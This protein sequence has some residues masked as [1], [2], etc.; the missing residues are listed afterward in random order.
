MGRFSTA[1]FRVNSLTDPN[2]A[3]IKNGEHFTLITGQIYY[4]HHQTGVISPLLSQ[5]AN[6]SWN[7]ISNKPTT[8]TGFG[9]SLSAADIP[10]LPKS[11]ISFGTGNSLSTFGITLSSSDI[12]T[13]LT[14]NNLTIN[15]TLTASGTSVFS[16]TVNF[17]S[18]TETVSF[19]NNNVVLNP[20][21]QTISYKPFI[22]AGT[23]VFANLDPAEIISKQELIDYVQQAGLSG[24]TLVNGSARLATTINITL[25]G[26]QVIDDNLTVEDD[27]ILVKNQTNKINNGL[28]LAKSGAW[29]RSPLMDSSFEVKLNTTVFVSGGTVNQNSSWSIT[30]PSNPTI[31]VD[32]INFTQFSGSQII[33]V[34]TGLSKVGNTISTTGLLA[35]FAQYVPSGTLENK[36]IFFNTSGLPEATLI[37]EQG[38]ELLE[39]ANKKDFRDYFKLADTDYTILKY[40]TQTNFKLSKTVGSKNYL[41]LWDTTLDNILFTQE[42]HT[43]TPTGTDRGGIRVTDISD[44]DSI[45]NADPGTQIN[46]KNAMNSKSLD[47]Y[48][49]FVFYNQLTNIPFIGDDLGVIGNVLTIKPGDEVTLTVVNI[50][51]VKKLNVSRKSGSTNITRIP[52][53]KNSLFI[54]ENEPFE[55]VSLV[56]HI[57]RTSNTANNSTYGGLWHQYLNESIYQP[58]SP[59]SVYNGTGLYGRTN[60]GEVYSGI[61]KTF[62]GSGEPTNNPAGVYSEKDLYNSFTSFRNSANANICTSIFHLSGSDNQ[63]D[64]KN[65]NTRVLVLV[66]N[67]K[68]NIVRNGVTEIVTI[69][70]GTKCFINPYCVNYIYI[71][72]NRITNIYRLKATP[73]APKYKNDV[74]GNLLLKVNT[75]LTTGFLH[76]MYP[77]VET[78]PTIRLQN[79]DT[80]AGSSVDL[81][82]FDYVFSFRDTTQE[83]I[84]KYFI[85]QPSTLNSF[86]YA[87]PDLHSNILTGYEFGKLEG[88][89]RV[90]YA[91]IRPP[92]TSAFFTENHSQIVDGVFN[93]AMETKLS[94]TVKYKFVKKI[95]DQT[96]GTGW[97]SD[98]N[99]ASIPQNDP[100]KW[101]Y[102]S[103]FLQLQPFQQNKL[104]GGISILVSESNNCSIGAGYRMDQPGK[105]YPMFDYIWIT[106]PNHQNLGFIV[107]GSNDPNLLTNNTGVSPILNEATNSFTLFYPFH[108]FVM[109]KVGQTPE[110]YINGM[111]LALTVMNTDAPNWTPNGISTLNSNF[112]PLWTTAMVP[113]TNFGTM[114]EGYVTIHEIAFG[115]STDKPVN[116]T[117]PNAFITNKETSSADYD[118]RPETYS[119]D[120]SGTKIVAWNNQK[121]FVV[122]LHREAKHM[123]YNLKDNTWWHQAP[124]GHH[125][126]K[127]VD[128]V[129]IGKTLQNPYTQ[130]QVF[131]FYN[132][133]EEFTFTRLNISSLVADNSDNRIIIRTNIGGPL[134]IRMFAKSSREDMEIELP[135]NFSDTDTVPSG[136]YYINSNNCMVQYNTEFGEYID[137]R[138][139]SLPAVIATPVSA[140]NNINGYNITELPRYAT[141]YTI[142][143]KYIRDQINLRV[144]IERDF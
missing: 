69:P 110:V 126:I 95:F 58:T 8:I 67:I 85:S 29:I 106:T 15:N 98:W 108:L 139:N 33:N 23:R 43:M 5:L 75:G 2:V 94:N 129:F 118:D 50:D 61:N 10:S 128:R 137:I 140:S 41:I 124:A 87:I 88:S 138:I 99:N 107:S 76:W 120:F 45:L 12:P 82:R 66:R 48:D 104:Y 105:P 91:I 56:E 13:N 90:S 53:Y 74:A 123:Y 92:S 9:I 47:S 121:D 113:R 21:V 14:L 79:G 1:L 16:G 34:G 3:K 72:R 30:G 96:P 93:K 80:N 6:V 141:G 117:Y 142:N 78:L 119:A 37:T 42:P 81:K 103:A 65:L 143:G 35:N 20:V 36:M 111:K 84:D 27:L 115:S 32:D 60:P 101:H 112:L 136:E 51:G 19:T 54:D 100:N 39:F 22:L 70:R 17:N 40:P 26:H 55:K 63:L 144:L 38:R 11:K 64:L 7:D 127:E 130:D 62:D 125:P 28:Y 44:T 25:S 114:E 24:L 71:E 122:N 68:I 59:Y 116:Y 77:M 86:N 52:K 57:S 4:K 31:D 49:V 102:I 73:V 109:F 135:L 18:A 46:I 89:A 132:Q 133:V 97:A 134:K 83:V 131:S